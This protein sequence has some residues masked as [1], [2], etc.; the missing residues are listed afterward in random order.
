MAR[1]QEAPTLVPGIAESIR[2]MILRG[3][4]K[5]GDVIHQTELAK[6]LGVSPAPLREAL[7]RLEGE[8]LVAFLPY[9]GTIVAPVTAT[10]VREGFAAAIALGLLMVPEAVPRLSAE[11][12]ALLRDLAE[13]LDRGDAG[14]DHVLRFYGT[15]LRPAGMPWI[16]E[17]FR[18]IVIRSV[19]I[20]PLTQANRLKL[21]DVR[22]TRRELVAACASGDPEAAK[23][24][25]AAYHEVRRAGLL[26]ALAERDEHA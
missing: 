6:E 15:L 7:R 3:A 1:I 19:R 5:E 26:A 23:A 11:D 13:V 16:F 14:M 12:L 18:N 21:Q 20:Y 25:F 2:G 17:L 4:L 8:G 10:E 22:P 24:V 9:K